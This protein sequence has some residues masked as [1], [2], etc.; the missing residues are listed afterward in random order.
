MF[1]QAL[2]VLKEYFSPQVKDGTNHIWHIHGV[3]HTCYNSP[4]KMSWSNY[5][6][7]KLLC[8]QMY[9]RHQKGATALYWHLHSMERYSCA[10]T[11]QG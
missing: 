6:N 4:L 1:S 8:P 9:I 11:Q 10:L 2:A 5:K 3:W 7:K